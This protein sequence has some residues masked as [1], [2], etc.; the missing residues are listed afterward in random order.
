MSHNPLY[1]E[2]HALQTVPPSN[3]NRDD[4]GSPKT[5]RFG[6]VTRARVSSQAWK[7]AIRDSFAQNLDLTDLGQR[8][9]H[10]V[11]LIA[12][13]IRQID[14]SIDEDQA[15]SMGSSALSATGVKVSK[16]GSTGYLL[17]IS[18]MQAEKL[19]HLAIEAQVGDGKID[20]KAAKSV[21]NVKEAPALNAI[22]IALFGRM[23]AD[24]P[25]LNVDAAVQVA[26]AI[27]VGRSEL[28]YDYFTAMDDRSPD[29][30]AGAAMIETTEFLSAMLYRY[31]TV[32]VYH[33]CENLGSC[34]AATRAATTFVRSFLTS[35]PS[36][37][38]NSFANRTLPSAIMVQI[39]G[40]QPVNLSNAF[41]RPVSAEADRGVLQ[42][43]CKRLI[44]QEKLTRKA[45]RT[46]P[47]KTYVIAAS[48]DAECLADVEGA[49]STNIDDLMD[50]LSEEIAAYL[51]E[52][53]FDSGV[54]VI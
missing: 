39:S 27:G 40:T 32:D 3:I 42:V 7:K 21:M 49:I 48:A 45:F 37:K 22:D 54:E 41:E 29:D 53:G 6:G 33:L 23:V 2:I 46:N 8:T 28:E 9:K 51:N 12:G 1:I 24:D 16:D 38:Q 20:S 10:A 25:S 52:C 11:E 35:M 18:P 13:S 26:H 43:A 44:E 47:L 5:A 36:G 14:S 34:S 30:N 15:T 31:A 19:A 50:G 4:T 17:F